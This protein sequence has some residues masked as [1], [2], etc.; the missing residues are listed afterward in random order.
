M[1]SCCATNATMETQEMPK[2]ETK[3]ARGPKLTI[4]MSPEKEQQ[5]EMSCSTTQAKGQLHAIESESLVYEPNRG[6]I[7]PGKRTDI[8]A[9]GHDPDESGSSDSDHEPEGVVFVIRPK[10]KHFNARKHLEKFLRKALEKV[11]KFSGIQCTGNSYDVS[12]CEYI[13]ELIAE[14]ATE[15]F[16]TV[17]FSN[18]F[19]TRNKATLPV[20]LKILI[21][22][23]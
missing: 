1:G 11:D 20:S 10:N 18:M 5:V 4:E 19:V 23:I 12:S 8:G 16:D 2:L 21:D 6:A 22:S 15:D 14:R 13:A 7:N 3:I 17:D 9:L